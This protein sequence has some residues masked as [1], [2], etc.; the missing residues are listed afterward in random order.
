M[1]CYRGYWYCWRWNSNGLWFN[2][3]IRKG[4]KQWTMSVRWNEID[5]ELIGLL[6][7]AYIDRLINEGE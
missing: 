4:N 3:F 1:V 2:V 6:A 7:C 5:Y